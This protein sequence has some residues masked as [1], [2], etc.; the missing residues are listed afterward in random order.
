MRKSER[1]WYMDKL[2]EKTSKITELEK[3]LLEV[4]K[5]LYPNNEDIVKQVGKEAGL[6]EAGMKFLRLWDHLNIMR[7]Y[8][9]EQL[10]KEKM[11]NLI[12]ECMGEIK[13]WMKK[14]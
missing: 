7:N 14:F 11:K 6:T 10:E 3:E 4:Y 2:Y 1:Q 5:H 8:H 9:K 13:Q 12:K